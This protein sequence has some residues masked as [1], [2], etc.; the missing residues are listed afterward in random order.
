MYLMEDPR[1]AS[2]PH[3]APQAKTD[4][5]LPKN[6]EEA[7]FFPTMGTWTPYGTYGV[8]VTTVYLVTTSVV[9]LL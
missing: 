4:D 9:F 2:E 3:E 7:F 6:S 5:V 1:T 8:L